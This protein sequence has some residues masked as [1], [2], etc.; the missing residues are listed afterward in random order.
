[1]T[2]AS[3]V[4]SVKD[5]RIIAID[6]ASHSLA[7]VIY[8]IKASKIK[9]AACGKINYKEYKGPS[10]KF[11]IISHELTK[12]YK[13]HKP[14]IAIIEQSI[15]IQ[16]FETSRIISYIIGYSWGVLNNFGCSVTDVNPL[17][18]KSGIGYKNLNKKEQQIISENG[19]KG[20][21]A[22]KLKKERKRRVQEIVKKYFNDLPEYLNDDDII[23]AA[24]IG[25]WYCQQI[26]EGSNGK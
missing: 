13:Q 20:S 17:V 23:D 4:S 3:L 26:I 5:T 2:I 11:A 10:A 22:V 24:G 21:L 9:I 12:V 8:D 16:N 14:F 19:E 18:W 6:P 7:W 15:Y 1:M 25:L